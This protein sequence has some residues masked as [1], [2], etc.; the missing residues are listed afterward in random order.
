MHLVLD[1]PTWLLLF[2]L[3]SL[4]SGGLGW[5]VGRGLGRVVARVEHAEEVARKTKRRVIVPPLR[6]RTLCGARFRRL[7][8]GAEV[9][10]GLEPGHK[11]AHAWETSQ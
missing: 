3:A 10:C 11:C 7:S 2:P 5:L 9:V 8:D 4:A 6:V 1:T